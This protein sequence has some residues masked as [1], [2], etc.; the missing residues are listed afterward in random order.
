LLFSSSF[1]SS[2]SFHLLLLPP[3]AHSHSASFVLRP[4]QFYPFNIFSSP[5]NFIT[6][7]NS[8]KR[9]REEE[10]EEEEEGTNNKTTEPSGGGR[11]KR[12]KKGKDEEAKNPG[13]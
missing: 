12:M 8:K 10:E 5:P 13:L 3:Q 4:A 9:R 7:T 6:G 2:S 11:R 1:P